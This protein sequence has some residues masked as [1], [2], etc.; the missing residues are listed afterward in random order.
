MK[1]DNKFKFGDKILN[2]W[3]GEYNPRR[4]G[5]FIRYCTS[6]GKKA[7]ECTDMNGDVWQHEASDEKLELIG[8]IFPTP[9]KSMEELT[10]EEINTEVI[11]IKGE[12]ERDGG[13][14]SSD[15]QLSFRAGARWV[16]SRLQSLPSKTVSKEELRSELIDF[17]DWIDEQPMDLLD[18]INIKA[19]DNYL[20][21]HII[22]QLSGEPIIDTPSFTSTGYQLNLN[23]EEKHCLI[24]KGCGTPIDSDYCPRCQ[25]LLES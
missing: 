15:E 9:S 25:R 13:N 5:I 2:H 1:N 12:F 18:V 24:C 23:N 22:K 16:L 4:I 3:A 11:R 6:Q 10:D 14:Y 21:D 8:S 20:R 19:V 7:I 17:C